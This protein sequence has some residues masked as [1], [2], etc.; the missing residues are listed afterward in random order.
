[1]PIE[2]EEVCLVCHYIFL[3]QGHFSLEDRFVI[4]CYNSYCIMPDLF[5]K[6]T[7]KRVFVTDERGG[8][9]TFSHITDHNA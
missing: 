2:E 8:N 9:I 6:P 4:C 5:Y 1:V 3:T 7:A